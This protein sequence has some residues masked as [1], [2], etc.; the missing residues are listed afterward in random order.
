MASETLKYGLIG[1]IIVAVII[2]MIDVIQ[3]RHHGKMIERF[4]TPFRNDQKF[5]INVPGGYLCG[6]D[7]ST[8]NPT[9]S[10]TSGIV[11]SH[12]LLAP[13]TIKLI[14]VF[15][16]TNTCYTNYSTAK[17]NLRISLYRTAINDIFNFL[18]ET[19]EDITSTGNLTISYTSTSGNDSTKSLLN[20]SLTLVPDP[21]TTSTLPIIN[22]TTSTL[23]IIN[24]TTSTRPII[25]T[26]TSTLPII[27]TTTSTRPIINTTTT[28]SAP[29]T[30]P[31]PTTTQRPTTTRG[32]ATTRPITTTTTT[33]TKYVD[34]TTYI[35]NLENKITDVNNK[36]QDS[37]YMLLDN[38]ER[39]D[40]LSGKMANILKKIKTAYGNTLQEQNILDTTGI[41]FY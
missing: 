4:T 31:A 33:T 14:P 15:D 19:L 38:Q 9:T 22:T 7:R 1:I 27:N 39:L 5:M 35:N 13:K 21:T 20:Y 12:T 6:I 3:K 18:P 29:T 28:T 40:Q 10:P 41:K 30:T 32:I 36:F 8:G 26:T 23:P 2:I 37:G 11:F 34:K 25:N 24:T 17:E 16:N